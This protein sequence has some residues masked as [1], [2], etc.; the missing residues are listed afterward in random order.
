MPLDHLQHVL[1]QTTDLEGTKNWWVDVLGLEVGPHPDF[2]V[3]V[4]WLYL[5]GRDVLHITTGGKDV[6]ENRRRYLG[7]ES[8]ATWGSG[9]VDHI[10]FHATGLHEMMAALDARGVD[11]RQRQITDQNLYQLF[12]VDP[13]GVKLELNFPAA[14]AVGLKAEVT[15]ADLD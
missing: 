3:P 15:A 10:A 5:N 1:I 6:G 11:Y 9:V 7:Q 13:N 4:Y 8:E 14:E 12:L 2:G